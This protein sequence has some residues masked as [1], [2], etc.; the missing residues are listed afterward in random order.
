MCFLL[1]QVISVWYH[2]VV[3]FIHSLATSRIERIELQLI[4]AALAQSATKEKL[5]IA[6]VAIYTA[7]HSASHQ[8]NLGILNF[9][10]FH[11]VG[12]LCLTH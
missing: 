12:M 1:I 4:E 8:S 9:L 7:T 2:P 3:D 5:L 11:L 6:A 10:Y